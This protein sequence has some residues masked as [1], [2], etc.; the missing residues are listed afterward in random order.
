M[1]KLV[2]PANPPD[3][4]GSVWHRRTCR[5]QPDGVWRVVF[6]PT[7][8]PT[9]DICVSSGTSRLWALFYKTGSAYQEPILG[10]TASGANQMVNKF[11]S[12]GEG[13]HS[14][15]WCIWAPAGWRKPVRIAD[16]HEPGKF[17]RLCDL[18]DRWWNHVWIEHQRSCRD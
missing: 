2:E 1:T 13:W 3:E 16:Q 12:L 9:N 18:H 15:S 10:T 8:I 6:F 14:V 7:F 11:G 5:Q 17:R 4:T